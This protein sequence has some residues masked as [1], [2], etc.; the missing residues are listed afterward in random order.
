MNNKRINRRYQSFDVKQMNWFPINKNKKKL[1][2]IFVI[3]LIIDINV[4]Y[5]I[6]ELFV[7]EINNKNSPTNVKLHRQHFLFE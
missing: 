5:R 4:K 3:E 2:E 1:H 7:V 6:F